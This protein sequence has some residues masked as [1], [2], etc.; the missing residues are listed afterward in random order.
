[1][2]PITQSLWHKV[3]TV[4]VT[5]TLAAILCSLIVIYTHISLSAAIADSVI[6][7]GIL[8]LTGYYYWYI[9]GFLKIF[10]TQLIICLAIQLICLGAT[11]MFLSV[12]EFETNDTFIHLIPLRLTV[13]LFS[14]LSL[15]QWYNL[16]D[17]KQ[18]ISDIRH[19]E[20][21]SAKKERNTTENVNNPTELLDHISVKD[22][23]KIHIIKVDDLIYIQAYGDYVML[24]TDTGKYVKELTMK[25]L[26]AN[27][28]ST[29]IRI[30]RSHIVNA[31]H[32]LRVEL[33]GKDT[34]QVKLKNNMYL[35]VSN[36]G[37]KILKDKLFL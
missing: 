25:F 7:I 11:F 15:M 32:I 26:E 29:F 19:E 9:A 18:Q 28:P 13:G 23:A 6:Y 33:F 31:N 22:G 24:F 35:R 3:I 10:Q 8:T 20:K 36:T 5:A 2:H 14:W 21:N 12:L 17:K 34:H 4:L 27:L 37:Y 16:S 30:H 1:M